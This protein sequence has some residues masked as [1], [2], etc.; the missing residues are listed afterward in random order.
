MDEEWDAV[1]FVENPDRGCG[2]VYGYESVSRFLDTN[3]LST[4]VRAHDVQREGY[5]LN[6][7]TRKDRD[8]PFVMTIFS[9]PNCK[10]FVVDGDAFFFQF[11]ANWYFD[12]VSFRSLCIPFFFS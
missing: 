4:I 12:D 1:D 11:L 2:F 5:E 8:L 9:A 3:K 6:Y 7:F 10:F